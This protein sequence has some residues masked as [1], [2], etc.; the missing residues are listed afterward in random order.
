MKLSDSPGEVLQK[1]EGDAGLVLQHLLEGRTGQPE[2]ENV[3]RRDDG[4]GSFASIDQGHLAEARSGPDRDRAQPV[5]AKDGGDT[6]EHDEEV[7]AGLPGRD[8][9]R[10]S[11]NFYCKKRDLAGILEPNSWPANRVE[12]WPIER[13]V[14]YARNA[15]THS[16]EQVGQV[17]ASIRE[18]GWT[19]PVLVARTAGSLPVIV[20][21]WR[22]GNWV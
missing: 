8:D 14:P 22:A 19:N 13:L 15:R 7:V 3:A 16:D 21:C 9:R 10:S 6:V 11:R 4:R 20:G 17:A 12:R 5:R 2:A 18:W 1:R